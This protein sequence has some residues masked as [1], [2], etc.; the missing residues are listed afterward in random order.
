METEDDKNIKDLFFND[1]NNITNGLQENELQRISKLKQDALDK[2]NVLVNSF[3]EN[4]VKIHQWNENHN[5]K[6]QHLLELTVKYEY[7]KYFEEIKSGFSLFEVLIHEALGKILDSDK[8]QL[9][10]LIS[11]LS[12]CRD[13]KITI[14]GI[15]SHPKK[16][17]VK[18]Q[19]KKVELSSQLDLYYLSLWANTVLEKAQDGLYQNEF[20]WNFREPLK[21]FNKYQSLDRYDDFYLEPYTDEELEKVLV[22]ERKK[23]Q[24]SKNFTRNAEY[25]RCLSIYYD[26][27]LKTGVFIAKDEKIKSGIALGITKEYCYMY[28]CL[29]L[30]EATEPLD[31][32]K[33]KYTK[34][35][36][37]ILSF[38]KQKSK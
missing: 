14:S 29:A 2:C 20:N 10:E 24:Q 17:E 13:N 26:F 32:N 30:L 3:K 12:S 31:D 38:E 22:Y 16:G 18:S 7:H 1:P 19:S 34:V 23:V 6:I 35:R 36:D 37:W 9:A 33:E 4:M 11:L 15:V 28:D 25:G 27:L 8:L 21:H 5:Q